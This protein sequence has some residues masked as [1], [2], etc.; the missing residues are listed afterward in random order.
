MKTRLV[1]LYF[2]PG[3]ND[4]FDRQLE[5]LNSLLTDNVEMLKP[6][7]LGAPLPDADAVVFPQLL[8]EAYRQREAFRAI[9]LPILVLTS[10]FGTLSMWDWEIIDYLR[11]EGVDMIAPYN[12]QQAKLICRALA[13][14]REPAL[15]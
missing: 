9:G 10:E 2:D 5:V 7:P 13:V 11:S 12:V 8:G 1:P 4:D 6:L 3:R 15:S 14:R